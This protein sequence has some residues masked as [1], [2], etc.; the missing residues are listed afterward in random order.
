MKPGTLGVVIR[1]VTE[2]YLIER[3]YAHEVEFRTYTGPGSYNSHVITMTNKDLDLLAMTAV[4]RRGGIAVIVS[5]PDIEACEAARI[6]E[7]ELSSGHP[8]GDD[9][10]LTEAQEAFTANVTRLPCGCLDN[11][12]GAHRVGCPAHPEG[13]PG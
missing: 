4:A 9:L 13:V 7:V 11:R 12:A 6:T 1:D 2:S 8:F 5:H 3:G 10:D